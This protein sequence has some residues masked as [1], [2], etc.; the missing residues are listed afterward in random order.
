MSGTLPFGFKGFS[1]AIAETPIGTRLQA[2]AD[3]VDADAQAVEMARAQVEGIQAALPAAVAQ[4]LSTRAPPVVAAQVAVQVDPLVQQALQSAAAAGAAAAARTRRAAGSAASNPGIIKATRPS[5]RSAVNLLGDVYSHPVQEGVLGGLAWDFDPVTGAPMGPLH[6]GTRTNTIAYGSS[7]AFNWNKTNLATGSATPEAVTAPDGTLTA[8]RLVDNATSGRHG[9][10]GSQTVVAGQTYTFSVWAQAESATFMQLC[11]GTLSN[12]FANFDLTTGAIGTVGANATARIVPRGRGWFMCSITSTAATSGNMNGN[13][14]LATGLT[15]AR[16]GTYVGAG[17]SLLIWAPQAELGPFAT[18]RALTTTAAPAI[19]AADVWEVNP[20][21]L[22]TDFNPLQ[23]VVVVDF[24]SWPGPFNGQASDWF[25]LVSLDDRTNANLL[26]LALS[27]T[28]AA[29]EGRLTR[30]G[31][32]ET[33]AT[34]AF[35]AAP[36]RQRFR[37]ALAYDGTRMQVAARGVAGLQR[38]HGGLPPITRLRYLGLGT[39]LPA[40]G[41]MPGIEVLPAAVWDAA[42]A[43]LT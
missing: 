14:L 16:L 24:A 42:L 1:N 34:A 37:Y 40:W 26:G 10:E 19:Q 8:R 5:T 11:F 29:L 32:A 25:G 36:A 15:M 33:P 4:E 35:T 7:M 18:P 13:I 43:A 17:S 39:G 31:V 6:G 30:A 38:T 2:A 28:H 22:G 20:T 9:V 12:A 3:Q 21:D 41:W 27:P 23:G